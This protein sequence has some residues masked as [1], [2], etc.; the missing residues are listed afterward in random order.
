M[1][2]SDTNEPKAKTFEEAAE[3]SQDAD[4]ADETAAYQNA[5]PTEGGAAEK[6]SE[7]HPS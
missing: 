6:D 7:A 3:I 4:I 5:S 2:N 1:T